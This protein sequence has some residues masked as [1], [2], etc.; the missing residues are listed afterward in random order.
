MTRTTTQLGRL[1]LELCKFRLGYRA[2]H[3]AKTSFGMHLTTP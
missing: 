2:V 1:T 3:Q